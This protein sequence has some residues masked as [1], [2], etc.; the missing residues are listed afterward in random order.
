LQSNKR[1]ELGPRIMMC[2]VMA[3]LVEDVNNGLEAM[4]IFG[5]VW[6]KVTARSASGVRVT[7]G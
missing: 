1:T 3:T 2:G 6:R 5:A 7:D 4:G